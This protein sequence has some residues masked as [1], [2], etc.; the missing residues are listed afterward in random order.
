MSCGEKVQ[1]FSGSRERTCPACSRELYQRFVERYVVGVSRAPDLKHVVLTWK[2]VRKQDPK[3]VR[4]IARA[5]TRLLHQ[6]WYAENWHGVLSTIECKKNSRGWFYYHVHSIVSGAYR[7]QEQL[8]EDWEAVS[9]HPIVFVRRIWRT[10][11]KAVRYVLKYILKG[12]N[13][14]KDKDIKD[15]K[16]SMRGVHY[17][18]SYGDFYGEEYRNGEHVYFPCPKCG[19]VRSWILADYLEFPEAREHIIYGGSDSFG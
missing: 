12:F 9:G 1:V 11:E 6:K 4:A 18:R 19:A 2:P 16:A 7:A 14:K 15:F 10:S 13:F 17:V 8:S 3:I 5:V